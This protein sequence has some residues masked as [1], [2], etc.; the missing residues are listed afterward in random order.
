MKVKLL[1]KIRKRFNWY[2][3]KTGFPV[4][5][6]HLKRCAIIIDVDFLKEQTDYSDEDVKNK[7]TISME[8]WAWNYLHNLILKPYGYSLK[9]IRYNI[10]I[11]RS[12]IKNRSKK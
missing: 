12:R 8:D 3:G 1:K 9:D 6:D 5:I 7:V 11:K 4:L 10:A 2:I